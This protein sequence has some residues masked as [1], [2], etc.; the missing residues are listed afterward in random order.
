M[1]NK[2]TRE[3]NAE[4][5]EVSDAPEFVAPLGL[6]TRL[7][8]RSR[9][10]SGDRLHVQVVGCAAGVSAVEELDPS[11]REA[12]L[13]LPATPTLPQYDASVSS[14]LYVKTIP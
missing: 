14:H 7:E 12:G 9:V 3:S 1:R 4:T 2:K 6:R 10:G 11:L 5:F 8:Q 13:S